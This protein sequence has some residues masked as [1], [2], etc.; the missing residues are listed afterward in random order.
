MFEFKTSGQAQEALEVYRKEK[1]ENERRGGKWAARTGFKKEEDDT[2]GK[3][4]GHGIGLRIMS[5]NAI[6]VCSVLIFLLPFGFVVVPLRFHAVVIVV[7]FLLV[8][9]L[10]GCLLLQELSLPTS[11][12]CTLAARHVHA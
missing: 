12:V 9:S 10:L 5:W 6:I 3:W 7:A 2:D 4:A 8:M 11:Q 1:S